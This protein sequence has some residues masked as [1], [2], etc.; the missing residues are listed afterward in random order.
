M[1][2]DLGASETAAAQRLYGALRDA[3]ALGATVVLASPPVGPG[4]AEALADRLGK[5]A[6]PR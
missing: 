1:I 6:G 2:L 4:L 5:A 3:D